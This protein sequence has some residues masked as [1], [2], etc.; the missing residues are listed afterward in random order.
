MFALA[1]FVVSLSDLP[2]FDT[3]SKTAVS[4]SKRE[5]AHH[6]CR[7]ELIHPSLARRDRRNLRLWDRHLAVEVAV[8]V[9]ACI[10][11]VRLRSCLQLGTVS[12]LAM[13]S[14][15]FSTLLARLCPFPRPFEQFDV[16]ISPDSQN[17]SPAN[18]AQ[19]WV[20]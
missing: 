17:P 15:D 9:H 19:L 13:D 8:H 1:E 16:D 10:L 6:A 2:Y 20:L 14:R 11:H 18:A 12:V 7:L 4:V 5:E 3:V